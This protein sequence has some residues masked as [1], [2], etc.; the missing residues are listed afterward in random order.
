MPFLVILTEYS[1]DAQQGWIFLG[2]GTGIKF[3]VL[4]HNV[5]TSVI[6]FMFTDSYITLLSKKGNLFSVLS[7]SFSPSLA[8]LSLL[9]FFSFKCKCS[10]SRGGRRINLYGKLEK[11]F[12]N[13][14]RFVSRYPE[15]ILAKEGEPAVKL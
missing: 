11:D 15:P 9:S 6:Y 4:G 2:S 3:K 8:P 7:F 14:F 10:I 5:V 12:C 13:I 1:Y